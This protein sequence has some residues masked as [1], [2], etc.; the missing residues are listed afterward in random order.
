MIECYFP[1]NVM[2]KFFDQRETFIKMQYKSMDGDACTPLL[3]CN[4]FHEHP[5]TLIPDLQGSPKAVL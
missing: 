2:Q 1:F 3:I 4:I 5:L